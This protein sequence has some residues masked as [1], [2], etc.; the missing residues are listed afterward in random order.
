MLNKEGQ[1]VTSSQDI[2]VA[3]MD[4]LKK[5]LKIRPIKPELKEY[6]SEREKT[7]W[8]K[9]K[10]CQQEYNTRLV[11]RW[12]AKCDKEFEEKEIK[13]PTWYITWTDTRGR[14]R[15]DTGNYKANEWNEKTT[16]LST[17]PPIM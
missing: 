8:K 2:K 15:C 13:G 5:V 7:V 3:A 6:K 14:D 4:H 16:S 9:A 17:L 11:W 10:N 12:C 1:L